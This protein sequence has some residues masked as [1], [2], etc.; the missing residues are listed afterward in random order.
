MLKRHPDL[1][2]IEN[3][4]FGPVSGARAVTLTGGGRSQWAIVRSLT[5]FLG[6]DL[7]VAI[8]AG[9]ELTVARVRARQ[10]VG[11][12]W[13]SHLLQHLALALWSDP[14]SGRHLARA[15]DTY[16]RRRQG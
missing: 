14:S 2:L 10:S 4:P 16:A 15:A 5:K 13:V 6:P 8:V 3:D 9:D 12:R 1:L 7:R 11:T